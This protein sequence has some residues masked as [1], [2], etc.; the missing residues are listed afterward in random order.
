MNAP[1]KQQ[2]LSYQKLK[3]QL[4]AGL[5]S[6]HQ[7]HHYAHHPDTTYRGIVA[8]YS[9][10]KEILDSIKAKE[11]TVNVLYQLK[12]NK[13]CSAFRNIELN[14]EDHPCVQNC[15]IEEL[16]SECHQCGEPMKYYERTTKKKGVSKK[17]SFWGW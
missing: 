9:S 11:S 12:I 2:E 5:L 10:S 3:E 7:Q 14:N 16:K 1:Q 13:N 6:S 17:R 4:I 15:A 8:K